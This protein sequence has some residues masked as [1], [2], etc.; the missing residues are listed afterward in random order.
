MTPLHVAA[1]RGVNS[2]IVKYL[3]DKEADINIKDNNGVSTV[4]TRNCAPFLLIR[5]SYKCGEGGGLM[6]E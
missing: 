6:I 1:E 5:F 2:D 3:V 4:L